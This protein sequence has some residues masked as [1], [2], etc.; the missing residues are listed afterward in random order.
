MTLQEFFTAN[1]KAAIAFDE[2]GQ[3][4]K[5]ALGFARKLGP[6]MYAPNASTS[7]SWRMPD[8]L[9]ESWTQICAYF[10]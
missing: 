1:P 5:A 9:P 8:G 7:L 2:S 6:I 4:T 10:R 3:P